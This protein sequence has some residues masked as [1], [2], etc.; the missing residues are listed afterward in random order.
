M[1]ILLENVGLKK[2]L[3]VLAALTS[4]Q[5]VAALSFKPIMPK[6]EDEENNR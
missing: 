4:I 3:Y 1:N 6:K 2:T 5:M